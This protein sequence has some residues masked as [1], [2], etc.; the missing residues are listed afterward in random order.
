MDVR[1]QD[2]ITYL[3]TVRDLEGYLLSSGFDLRIIKEGE[4]FPGALETACL[5]YAGGRFKIAFAEKFFD[6]MTR[7]ERLAVL[8]H[9][10]A[11]FSHKHFAR[12]DG[13][14]HDIWNV[15]CDIAINQYIDD[16]PKDCCKPLSGMQ[17]KETAEHYYKHLMDNNVKIVGP[18]S[19]CGGTGRKPKDGKDGKG[20]PCPKCEGKGH[21]GGPG[22]ITIFDDMR[23]GKSTLETAEAEA[24]AGTMIKDVIRDR[25]QNGGPKERDKLRGLYGGVFE[26]LIKELSAKPIISWKA[27][28][29]RFVASFSLYDTRRTLKRPDRRRISPWGTRKE[30]LP[31]LIVAIDTSGSI[32]QKVLLDFFGQVRILGMMLSE[33]RVIGCDAEV[34]LDVEYR[35]G[36]EKRL[37]ITGRGGTDFDPVVDLVNKKYR[38]YDG[39]I[40]L[41]DGE[42]PL[43]KNKSKVPLLWVVVNNKRFPGKP[44][45][46]VNM[47]EY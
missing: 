25:L 12:I 4:K 36:M 37:K 47:D 22:T 43:P 18:C 40:Y 42:C 2:L 15:A 16:L 23:G 20:E 30:R 13:R 5:Y 38:D 19:A 41:T 6:S 17:K 10:I 39:L 27:A 44:C 8:R 1:L 21:D 45:T 3:I 28:I 7:K 46:H 34:G 32:S 11:H 9:E 33:I 14:I 26:E 29:S 24:A 31:K 35:P